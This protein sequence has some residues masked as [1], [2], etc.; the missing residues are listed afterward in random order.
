VAGSAPTGRATPSAIFKSGR[1]VF[2]PDLGQQF[3][4]VLPL[5]A[6]GQRLGLRDQTGLVGL[7][8]RRAEGR[9]PFAL[10]PRLLCAQFRIGAMVSRTRCGLSSKQLP[11]QSRNEIRRIRL[12]TRNCS[13]SGSLSSAGDG[14]AAVNRRGQRFH[15]QVQAIGEAV[16]GDFPLAQFQLVQ[17]GVHRR[18]RHPVGGDLA[19]YLEHQAS[20]PSACSGL[21]PSSP[22]TKVASRVEVSKPHSGEGAAPS[23]EV[24]SALPQRRAAVVQQHIAQKPCARSVA[25]GSVIGPS[26]QPSTIWVWSANSS[27]PSSG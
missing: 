24:S 14:I 17:G 8:E 19:Q 18:L 16:A 10:V 23:S 21:E 22:Q 9:Q 11:G 6:F 27:A 12:S 25:S 15:Q 2:Q 3:G 1:H 4:I 26:S 13:S 7:G 5:L 20:T